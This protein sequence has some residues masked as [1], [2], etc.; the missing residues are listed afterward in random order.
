MKI[1]IELDDS[2]DDVEVIIKTA[3]LTDQVHQL[4]Q[5][6]SQ[7][8]HPSLVFY[9]DASEYF[10]RLEEILFF[11]TDGGKIFAHSRTDAYEVRLKLYELEEILPIIFCRISKSSIANVRSV[12][13][14]D[15][16]FSGTS[17]IRFADTHKVVHVSRRYYQLLKERL[18]EL[19]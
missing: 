1:R 5:L 9:K 15:K 16:S 7:V 11:E 17:R 6:L 3:S 14:L 8:K 18:Q 4:Q 12:Y 2:L 10:V 13:S 19:R